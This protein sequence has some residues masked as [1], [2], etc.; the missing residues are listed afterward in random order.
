MTIFINGQSNPIPPA[1]SSDNRIFSDVI[2]TKPDTHNG[3]SIAAF[4]HTI[5]E[6]VHSQGDVYPSLADDVQIQTAAGVWT[7]GNFTE[8]V[9]VNGIT[10]DFD[11]HFVE[12]STASG[13]DVF[14]LWL[15]AVEV[16]RAKIRFARTTNQTRVSAK[17]TQS[18]IMP[19]NTQIQ[20][21]LA[22]AAGGS[23]TADI[24]IQFHPY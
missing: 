10:F 5:L 13:N 2:G 23:K 6:H 18:I 14:E 21:K 12:I 9:P 16:L 20:G 15:Y 7:L 22:C 11:L 17:P 19:A 1:D 3:D 8:I 4:C 24:S